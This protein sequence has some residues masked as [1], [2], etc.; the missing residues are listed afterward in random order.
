MSRTLSDVAKILEKPTGVLQVGTKPVPERG[1][2][3][4]LKAKNMWAPF[5]LGVALSQV[6]SIDTGLL[7]EVTSRFDTTTEFLAASPSQARQVVLPSSPILEAGRQADGSLDVRLMLEQWRDAGM[8]PEDAERALLD[9]QPLLP[10]F[11]GKDHPLLEQQFQRQAMEAI[12]R[13]ESWHPDVIERLNT[14]EKV[15]L[16]P[17]DEEYWANLINTLESSI[18]HDLTVGQP[19]DQD[20]SLDQQ[21]NASPDRAGL[22]HPLA[23]AGFENGTFN[24]Q[25]MLDRWQR[26]GMQVRDAELF[27]DIMVEI[28]APADNLPNLERMEV[29]D[30]AGFAL[31]HLE[32]EWNDAKSAHVKAHLAQAVVNPSFQAHADANAQQKE[33]EFWTHLRERAAEGIVVPTPAN[34]TMARAHQDLQ[35]AMTEVGLGS[36]RLSLWQNRSPEAVAQ[37]AVLLKQANQELQKATGWSGRTLGM[38]GRL[39]LTMGPV[40]DQSE[41]HAFVRAVNDTHSSTIEMTS[42]W[43]SL[44]HEWFHVFDHVL[45]RQVLKHPNHRPLSENAQM[46]R[47]AVNPEAKQAMVQ[48]NRAINDDS[49][50]W[51]RLRE[52]VDKQR[53]SIYFTRGTEAG[54]YAFAAFLDRSGA[55]VLNSNSTQLGYLEPHR[56][57]SVEEQALHQAPF[58][59]LFEVTQRFHLDGGAPVGLPSMTQW[60]QARHTPAPSAPVLPKTLMAP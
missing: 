50:H 32:R 60:R 9:I 37:T 30:N 49:P 27:Y 23:Q 52:A 8:V 5:L 38:D 34:T 35:N 46:F 31:E 20:R 12:G 45:A 48:L 22:L 26:A 17:E 28:T 18:A 39:N 21:V 2:A 10:V 40:I 15:G 43:E 24:S 25:R 33:A 1:L 16:T 3:K 7:N 55:V 11:M 41:A 14:G 42:G 56:V 6:V 13:L 58:R 54:A 47:A 44:G 36:F 59:T 57:P 4:Y 53:G 29:L 51:H 19:A